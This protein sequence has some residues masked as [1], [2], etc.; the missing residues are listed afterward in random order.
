MIYY[1]ALGRE[2][3][4]L[5]DYLDDRGAKW[6]NT[7]V[8]IPYESLAR[9]E[10]LPVG[11]YIFSDL[12]RL[13]RAQRLLVADLYQHLSKARPDLKLLNDPTKYLGR[14]DLLRALHDQ[15]INTFNVYRPYE[16]PDDIRFPVFLRI[17]R[18]HLG[19]RTPLLRNHEELDQA[20]REM[21]CAGAWPG[22]VL[23]VEFCDTSDAQG[24]FRKYAVWR[25]G[26]YYMARHKVVSDEWMQ[27]VARV[28]EGE[29]LPKAWVEEERRFIETNPHLKQVRP[30]FEMA[31]IEYG[32][33]DYGI[34]DGRVQVWEINTNP[35]CMM[36]RHKRLPEQLPLDDYVKGKF[37]EGWRS[38]NCP[39]PPFPPIPYQLDYRKLNDRPEAEWAL[40]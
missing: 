26:D 12:D 4:T 25:F 33:I 5:T 11:T 29:S 21:I 19:A 7:I 17:E 37:D 30:A 27:K 35:T 23:V 22:N 10:A 34:L 1:L 13:S 9:A 15:G 2:A 40:G 36:P 3:Y 32:R 31:G 16:V 39:H 38:I 8:V 28:G 14:F 18:D 20:I 6:R 24:I